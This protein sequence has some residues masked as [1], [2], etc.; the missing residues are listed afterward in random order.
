MNFEWDLTDRLKSGETFLGLRFIFENR[1][2]L[3]R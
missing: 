2:E 3:A 1:Y